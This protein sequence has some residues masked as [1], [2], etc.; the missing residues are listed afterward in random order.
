MI[1]QSCDLLH[2]IGSNDINSP[3]TIR[4]S[5]NQTFQI[6]MLSN[7]ELK[8]LISDW[9]EKIS[10]ELEKIETSESPEELCKWIQRTGI[11]SMIKISALDTH[12]RYFTYHMCGPS[13]PSQ[14]EYPNQSAQCESKDGRF[15]PIMF[16]DYNGHYSF[17][18]LF[19]GNFSMMNLSF[20]TSNSERTSAVIW[21]LS[22]VAMCVCVILI[23]ACYIYRNPSSNNNKRLKSKRLRK[24]KQ[25]H[26]YLIRNNINTGSPT[27]V[28]LGIF[29]K[30]GSNTWFRDFLV[31]MF[32]QQASACLVMTIS[33]QSMIEFSS[34]TMTMNHNHVQYLANSSSKKNL[35]QRRKSNRKNQSG[36]VHLISS[37]IFSS[38]FALTSLHHFYKIYLYH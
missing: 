30:N 8:T 36:P 13:V 2:E 21:V 28:S 9:S 23:S 19:K 20:Q 25:L 18:Q 34:M 11:I 3:P 24:N 10:A 4:V 5:R 1:T 31:D 32:D 27:L 16:Q 7:E 38:L 22:L 35:N 17:E 14:L 6:E 12:V 15:V 26:K 33:K 37:K 29:L